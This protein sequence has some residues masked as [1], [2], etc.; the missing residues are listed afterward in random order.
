[1]RELVQSQQLLR[2]LVSNVISCKIKVKEV[3][4]F[5]KVRNSCISNTVF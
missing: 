3:G 5:G 1:M 4:K 2:S